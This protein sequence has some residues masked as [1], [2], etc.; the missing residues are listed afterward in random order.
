M[1][2]ILPAYEEYATRTDREIQSS[3][4]KWWLSDVGTRLNEEPHWQASTALTRQD[5]AEAAE[6]I[7]RAA[8]AVGLG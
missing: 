4:S 6:V 5:L 3:F 1:L 2:S 8:V 7:L